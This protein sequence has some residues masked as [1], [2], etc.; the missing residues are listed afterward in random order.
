[1]VTTGEN[2]S[3]LAL[4]WKNTLDLEINISIFIRALRESNFDLYVLSLL[5]LIKWFFALDHYN[6]A[7]CLSVHLHDLLFQDTDVPDLYKQFLSGRKIDS[8]QILLSIN[9]TNKIMLY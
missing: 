4:H 3:K 7:R 2:I 5:F 8:F 6:F 1:M 9:F